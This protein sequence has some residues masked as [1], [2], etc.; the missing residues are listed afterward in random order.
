MLDK[1]SRGAVQIL[2]TKRWMPLNHFV[3]SFHVLNLTATLL[4][5]GRSVGTEV[6]PIHSEKEPAPGRTCTSL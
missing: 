4:Y 3:I 6:G 1:I 5:S 2:N